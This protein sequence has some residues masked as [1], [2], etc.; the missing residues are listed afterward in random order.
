MTT[1]PA[2]KA[3][4]PARTP[5]PLAMAWRRYRRSKLGVLGGWMLVALYLMALF[6]GFLSPYAIDT[7]H[8]EF[9]YQPPQRI[10]VMHDGKVMR[11]FVYPITKQRDPVT[12][13]N[14]YAEDRTRPNPIRLLVRGEEY[15]LLGVRTNLHLF[16]VRDG[17]FFPFGTD[18]LGRDLLS[19]TLVGSQVSLTVGVI[20]VLISFSIGIL[21][22][23][24]SGFYGGR[25]DNFIQRI[26]EVLLS[27]PRLPILLALSTLV[28]ARWPSTWVYLGIVAVLALIG[29]ASLARV[30]RGQVLALRQIEF[31]TAA[32][33][34][35]ASDLRVIWRHIV[36][37]LSSFLVVTATLAL[38]GYILGESALSFLGLGIK[39]PMTSWGLLLKD[40]NKIEVLG[41]S[42]WL[43]LPGAFIVVSVLAFNFFGDALRDAADTQS[44]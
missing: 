28:P 14:K 15:R 6:A 43:L 12:F 44:R 8:S 33:A 5:G 1:A 36:P 20:G 39:E 27:F 3:P 9:P 34:V 16:G 41:Q 21:M 37:N 10:H 32:G 26:V 24:V 2:P 7:Q 17:Y 35:G 40:A 11:P 13:V 30:V 25:V 29:W 18:Q 4:A 31:V 23:G 42:P 38:P 19:R 22:G